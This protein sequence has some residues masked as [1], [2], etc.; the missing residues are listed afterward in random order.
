[1]DKIT[2]I[3]HRILFLSEPIDSETANDLIGQL[4]LLD[5]DNHKERIDLYINSPGGNVSDG[6]AIMDA[7]Q[8]IEAPVSTVCIG[9]AASMGAWI[10]AGGVKGQRYAS[11]NAEIMIHQIAGGIRG[12]NSDIQVHAQ[13]MM[14]M[15]ERLITMLSIWTGQTVENI[16]QDMERDFFMTA[17]DAKNYGII[18]EIIK[19]F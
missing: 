7:I 6:L 14:R 10:L 19:P 4:L 9:Q 2:L 11:P 5:A 17:E 18:D 1:M 16:A 12:E 15:Q 13:R 8:C 3:Q